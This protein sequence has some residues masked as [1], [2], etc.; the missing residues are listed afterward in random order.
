MPLLPLRLTWMS[1]LGGAQSINWPGLRE[2][3][4]MRLFL[5]EWGPNQAPRR[6]QLKPALRLSRLFPSTPTKTSVVIK[7]TP[8]CGGAFLAD[9]RTPGRGPT[10]IALPGPLHNPS[11]KWR[12]HELVS[13]CDLAVLRNELEVRRIDRPTA[14]SRRAQR[15]RATPLDSSIRV[16]TPNPSR[17]SAVSPRKDGSCTSRR[18]TDGVSMGR[19]DGL[20]VPETRTEGVL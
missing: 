1:Y 14:L 12:R 8:S 19:S 17:C 16:V 7:K 2:V 15:G 6:G 3:K 18:L 10:R 5:T 20:I 13:G 9:G 4:Q 11:D